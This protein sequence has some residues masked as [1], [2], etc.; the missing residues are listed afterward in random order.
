MS[1]QPLTPSKAPKKPSGEPFFLFAAAFCFILLVCGGILLHS[2]SVLS[3]RGGFDHAS[4]FWRSF[5]TVLVACG[6]AE[7]NPEELDDKNKEVQ[8]KLAASLEKNPPKQE[9]DQGTGESELDPIGEAAEEGEDGDA[10]KASA[11]AAEKLEA[12][13]AAAE[14]ADAAEPAEEDAPGAEEEAP[15]DAAAETAAAE[16]PAA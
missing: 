15:A 13:K 3:A 14:A 9:D 8:D 5:L 1:G 10:A 4:W 16:E 6:V 2:S 11:E 12:L 7:M